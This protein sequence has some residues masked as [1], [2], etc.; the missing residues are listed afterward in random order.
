MKEATSTLVKLDKKWCGKI[1]TDKFYV[2]K[3]TENAHNIKTLLINENLCSKKDFVNK[4]SKY[5]KNLSDID[6][7]NYMKVYNENNKEI[8]NKT[9]FIKELKADKLNYESNTIIIIMS[10]GLEMDF[11]VLNDNYV[12]NN[13]M[14]GNDNLLLMYYT[15][16]DYEIISL[17]NKILFDKKEFPDEIR[18]IIDRDI[19]LQKHI[20][21]IMKRNTKL[22]S[23]INK[24][25]EKLQV[26]FSKTDLRNV[27]KIIDSHQKN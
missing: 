12:I 10:N 27:I 13:Y 8:K 3:T 16:E 19:F 18:N 22:N 26:K 6:F 5:I 15:S 23:V 7:I 11:L 20:Q 24:L 17:E 21:E 2:K 1:L 9:Q 4:I 25:E 14:M